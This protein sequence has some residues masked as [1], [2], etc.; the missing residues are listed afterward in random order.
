MHESWEDIIS[1]EEQWTEINIDR[2]RSSH[3]EK[4]YLKNYST[5]AQV[6]AEL[7]IHLEDPLSTKT[8]T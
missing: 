8:A 7:N 3:I 5:A 4:D 1:E 6:T 2:K